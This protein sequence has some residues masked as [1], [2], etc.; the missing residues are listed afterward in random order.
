M[1]YLA[2]VNKV[3]ITVTLC[4]HDSMSIIQIKN[5]LVSDEIYHKDFRTISIMFL[6]LFTSSLCYGF[7]SCD[8]ESVNVCVRS[9]FFA[10]DLSYSLSFI[11]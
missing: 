6:Y 10:R 8:R 4:W 1:L 3:F 7:S 2:I 5:N 9:Y 11:C